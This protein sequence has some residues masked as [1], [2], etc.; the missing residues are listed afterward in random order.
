MNFCVLAT[1]P[2]FITYLHLI[3]KWK[4]KKDKIFTLHTKETNYYIWFSNEKYR[5]LNFFFNN[6]PKKFYKMDII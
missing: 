1:F 2:F 5:F 3:E 6:F 4:K